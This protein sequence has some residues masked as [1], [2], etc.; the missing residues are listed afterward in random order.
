[1]FLQTDIVAALLIEMDLKDYVL[2]ILLGSKFYV[3]S[4]SC[5]SKAAGPRT[6]KFAQTISNDFT[7]CDGN[8]TAHPKNFDNEGRPHCIIISWREPRTG[9]LRMENQEV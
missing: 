8:P 2:S 5:L 3:G 4:T 9:A 6:D 1:M 7:S